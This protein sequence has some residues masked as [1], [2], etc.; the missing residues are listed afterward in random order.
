MNHLVTRHPKD[1][2]SQ[3]FFFLYFHQLEELLK[4]VFL[5]HLCVMFCIKIV[6]SIIYLYQ[7]ICYSKF[8]SNK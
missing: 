4:Y 6:A 8:H 2:E 5:N 1:E 7:L 3:I